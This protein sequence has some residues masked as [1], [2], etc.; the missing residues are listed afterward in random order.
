VLEGFTSLAARPGNAPVLELGG[1]AEYTASVFNPGGLGNVEVVIDYW[2]AN[3]VQGFLPR[4]LT[5]PSGRR[6]FFYPTEGLP[7][8]AMYASVR[9]D[10]SAGLFIRTRNTA[11]GDVLATAPAAAAA[12]IAFAHA[13]VGLTAASADKRSTLLIRNANGAGDDVVMKFHFDD[14]LVIERAFAMAAFG[15]R[16]MRLDRM[17][18]LRRGNGHFSITIESANGVIAG[19]TQWT[20]AGGWQATGSVVSG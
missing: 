14:G 17:P 7:A 5:I 2:G 19:L 1:G 8:G 13:E 20:A 9:T 6:A 18:A 12:S 11:R 16:A 4:V 15:E 10:Q 3:G